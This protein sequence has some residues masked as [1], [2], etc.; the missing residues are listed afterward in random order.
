MNKSEKSERNKLNTEL[1]HQWQTTGKV[2]C[3]CFNFESRPFNGV[4][5]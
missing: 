5:V 3:S 2:Q 1:L 4:F